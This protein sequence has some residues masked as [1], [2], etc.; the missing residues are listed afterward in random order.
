MITLIKEVPKINTLNAAYAKIAC[1]AA[2]YADFEK[3]AL[4]WKQTDEN[5]N[6]TALISMVDGV[7]SLADF[8]GDKFEISEFLK[9]IAPR[10]VFTDLQTANLLKLKIET[11]CDTLCIHPPYSS[12]GAAENT[13]AGIDYACKCVASRL[14]VGDYD[15]FK[16]DISHRIRHN[17]CGYVTTPFS[18]AFILYTED[19]SILSGIAVNP[20]TERSGLGSSTLKRLLGIARHRPMIVCAEEKNTPF[21]LKNGFTKIK[22][23]AY[24][25][26]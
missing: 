10:G 12:D 11:P 2:A 8:G 1:A 14:N 6:I 18:A 25:K 21:Y 13:Y 16:A 24:C 3:I 22:K 19:I 17:C 15:V 9:Y 5:D 23:F 26:L 20:T 4:F 7:V